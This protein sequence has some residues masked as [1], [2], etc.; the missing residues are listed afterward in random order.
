M[1]Q[2]GFSGNDGSTT[3]FDYWSVDTICR[4]RSRK[5]TDSEQALAR[6]YNKVLSIAGT[7]K[8][9]S[10][11]VMYDVM[12]VNRQ[13]FRQYA[14]LRK[15]G[16]EL[17]LVVANFDDHQLQMQVRIPAHAFEFLN[18]KERAAIKATDLLT[19]TET[20]LPLLK[21]GAIEVNLEA[22]GSVVYKIRL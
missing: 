3:I 5:L 12:Y 20:R 9:V 21:D 16:R 6:I 17:L 13:Y 10:E 19:D 7:E 4:E 2:E 8:A 15:A 1:D 18:I 14:F 11:G 22:R